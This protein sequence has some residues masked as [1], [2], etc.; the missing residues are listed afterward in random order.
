MARH[1]NLHQHTFYSQAQDADLADREVARRGR[2]TAKD[3]AEIQVGPDADY[4]LCGPA[5]F[6]SAIISGLEDLGVPTDRIHFETFGPSV[7]HS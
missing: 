2:V 6:I 5:K 1:E 3:I 7:A 4:L